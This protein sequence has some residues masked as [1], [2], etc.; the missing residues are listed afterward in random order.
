MSSVIFMITPRFLPC[1]NY[2]S[3]FAPAFA[4]PASTRTRFLAWLT[5]IDNHADH[6]GDEKNN[7]GVPGTPTVPGLRFRHGRSGRLIPDP[8]NK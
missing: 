4:R 5:Q 2:S 1:L 8:A 7:I 3:I 6:E